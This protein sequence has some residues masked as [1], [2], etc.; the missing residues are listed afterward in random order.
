MEGSAGSVA[1]A[2]VGD[3]SADFNGTSFDDVDGRDFKVE[4]AFIGVYESRDPLRA[5][6]LAGE[7]LFAPAA[8]PEESKLESRGEADFV[9]P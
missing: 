2:R 4:S 1:V 6:R 3:L 7:L 8:S 5:D 9:S